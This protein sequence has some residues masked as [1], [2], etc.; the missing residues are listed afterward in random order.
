MEL[1]ILDENYNQIG[2]FEE[3]ES[4]IWEE[5]YS[6]AGAFEIVCIPS[7]K[8]RKFMRAGN[9][10]IRVDESEMIGIIYSAGSDFDEDGRERWT[11]SGRFAEYLLHKRIV[12][13]YKNYNKKHPL[14]IAED[15]IYRNAISPSDQVRE[16]PNLQY[17][18]AD[19]PADAITGQY[20]GENLY[21]AIVSLCKSSEVGM[22]ATLDDAN[23]IVTISHYKG[24]DRTNIQ[25]KNAPVTL[26][27]DYGTLKSAAWA[28]D[29]SEYANIAYVAGAG[30][31]KSRKIVSTDRKASGESRYEMFI[32]ARD[33]QQEDSSGAALS[34][35]SYTALLKQR[36]IEDLKERRIA[37]NCDVEMNESAYKFREDFN[38][39]DIVSFESGNLVGI[40]RIESVTEYNSEN[41]REFDAGLEILSFTYADDVSNESAILDENYDAIYNENGVVLMW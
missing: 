1:L 6:E 16:I 10:V 24:V 9:R 23:K 38:L 5:R 31:G 8:T 15:L 17:Q 20:R 32:D 18:K 19:I 28:E 4:L 2:F 35:V 30:D 26:S 37:R 21:D 14:D 29:E 41:G 12:A 22:R 3:F 33:L 7:E 11:A 25:T 39:G 40:A 27:V 13:D 34:E 36:G